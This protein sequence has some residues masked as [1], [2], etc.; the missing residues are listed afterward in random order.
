[1]IGI[2]GAVMLLIW[3][4]VFAW[5]VSKGVEQARC[6]RDGRPRRFGW[7]LESMPSDDEAAHW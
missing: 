7:L 2:G 1:M 6:T 3:A 4:A 5:A